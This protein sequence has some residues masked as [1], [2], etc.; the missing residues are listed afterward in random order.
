MPHPLLALVLAAVAVA[1][2]AAVAVWIAAAAILRKARNHTADVIGQVDA[3]AAEARV[4]AA[5]TLT[6]DEVRDLIH[7]QLEVSFGPLADAIAAKVTA[8]VKPP[9][10]PAARKPAAKAGDAPPPLASVPPVKAPA[11]RASR[12]TGG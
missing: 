12:R 9:R 1:L 10:K 3:R 5:T 6:I 8:V 7:D 4:N 2:V 11:R